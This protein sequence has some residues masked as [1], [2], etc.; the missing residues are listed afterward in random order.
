MHY[1]LP[2]HGY[3]RFIPAEQGTDARGLIERLSGT[4]SSHGQG[5]IFLL[6]DTSPN[7]NASSL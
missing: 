1:T 4:A 2:D 6:L 7:V 5:T 3:A